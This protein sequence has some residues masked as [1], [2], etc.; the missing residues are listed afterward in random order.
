MLDTKKVIKVGIVGCGAIG[1]YIAL[2][3]QNKDFCKSFTV[4]GVSDSNKV[5]AEILR[6][7]LKPIVRVYDL[8]DLISESDL[9]IE[10]ASMKISFEVAKLACLA[11]KD[12]LI[13]SV[14]G[15][16]DKMEILEV[17]CKNNNCH[18][19]I[20]SGAICGLD[21][22][23]A[24]KIGRI[25]GVRLTTRKPPRGLVGAP[26]LAIKKIDVTKIKKETLIFE[27]NAKVAVKYFPQN[28]NVAAILS[29]CGVGSSKTIVRIVTSPI[30]TKNTHEVEVEGDFGKFMATTI[31]EPSKE[32][33]KTSALAMLSAIAKLK[34]MT[35]FVKI[36]T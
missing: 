36:G 19:H 14:G 33:P 13:M 32:N 17:L 31:N 2:K 5:S 18:I 15:L 26:Y 10:A 4:I 1:S 28:I 16:I 35:S 12:A 34:D 21:G 7:K 3:L 30:Y 9:V 25:T 8:V 11:G 20:P 27:G 6:K 22:L 29:M 24:A 23:K